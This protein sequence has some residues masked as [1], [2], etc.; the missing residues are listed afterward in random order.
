MKDFDALKDIWTAQAAVPKL[1]PEDTLRKVKQAKAGYANKLLIESFLM[2]GIVLFLAGVW[3][4][5]PF[6]LWTSHVSLALLIVCCIYYLFVQF[7]DY[8]GITHDANYLE[9]PEKY[10]TYLK[11]HRSR[12]YLL[13]TR[14]YAA[15]SVSIGLAFAL[16]FIE[17][18]LAAPLWQTIAG[19]SF[20]IAWFV[21]CFIWMQSYRKREQEKLSEMILNLE[22]IQKQFD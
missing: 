6:V 20:T 14:T 10:I 1:S 18:F 17:V 11:Q 5:S 3:V 13:N 21:F 12:R 7:N 15:Y 2:G 19:V 9:Q 8:R 16:Y 22:K 4:F